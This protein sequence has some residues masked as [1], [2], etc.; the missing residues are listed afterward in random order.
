MIKRNIIKILKR[1]KKMSKNDFSK[2]VHNADDGLIDDLC[3]CVFNVI[4]T[5]LNFKKRKKTCLKQHIHKNCSKLRLKKIMN[6]KL[7]LSKRRTA[8][9]QEG[10]GL[11]FLL[12]SAIPFITSL[13]MRK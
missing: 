5:D 6:K 4:N 1:I 9:K 10:R 2:F 3:E 13:F 7:P 8:L 12:A 11:P